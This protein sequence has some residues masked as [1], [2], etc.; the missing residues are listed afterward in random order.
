MCVE[1]RDLSFLPAQSLTGSN[2]T[3][4]NPSVVGASLR[5]LRKRLGPGPWPINRAESRPTGSCP[6]LGGQA[7]PT[8]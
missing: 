5:E 8:P 4:Q 6:L 2:C 3:K 1:D 7:A